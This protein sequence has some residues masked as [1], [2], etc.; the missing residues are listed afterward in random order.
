MR[1]IVVKFAQD[2]ALRAASEDGARVSLD[3]V[4]MLDIAGLGGM[5]AM[6]AD[7][8]A[9]SG[10]GVLQMSGGDDVDA[11]IEKLNNMPSKCALRCMP[12]ASRLLS[13]VFLRG[14]RG[15]VQR[16]RKTCVAMKPQ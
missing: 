14:N 10:I 6:T 11:M 4:A 12:A 9:A 15:L 7:V 3:P 2:G 13:G 8:D 5:V 16:A 1:R